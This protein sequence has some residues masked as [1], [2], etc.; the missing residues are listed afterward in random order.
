MAQPARIGLSNPY[1]DGSITL[2]A[3]P[4]RPRPALA[5][6][7]V[8]AGVTSAAAVGFGGASSAWA[9]GPT[10]APV[11]RYHPGSIY[12]PLGRQPIM[13]GAPASGPAVLNRIGTS[14]GWPRSCGSPPWSKP[15]PLPVDPPVGDPVDGARTVSVEGT[16]EDGVEPGCVVLSDSDGREWTLTG[17]LKK[18]P[19]DVPLTVTGTTTPDILTTCMQGDVLDVRRVELTD[20]T[21]DPGSP[22]PIAVT[23]RPAPV[24]RSIP[25]PSVLPACGPVVDGGKIP[26]VALCTR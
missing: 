6:V 24:A 7:A 22:L 18:L 21:P 20:G 11:V 23:E 16:V 26:S 13:A 1:D 2:D 25:V 15:V 17:P 19:H 5:R 9:D 12:C 8:V 4:A 14:Q 10:A 3:R